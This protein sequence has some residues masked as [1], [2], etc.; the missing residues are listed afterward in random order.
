[1]TISEQAPEPSLRARAA[2]GVLWTVAQKWGV[3]V[4]SLVTLAVL[5]RL[6]EPHEFGVV[7]MAMVYIALLNL[8]ADFGFASYVVQA[9][10]PDQRLLSTAFWFSAGAS[11]LLAALMTA[12]AP[13]VAALVHTPEL[14]PVLQVLALAVV[15]NGCVGT[16]S[17]LLKR[18][19][20]FRTLALRPMVAA[21]VSQAVAVALAFLGAGVWAL[22]AQTLVFSVIGG[23]VIWAGANWR[24]SLMFSTADAR[25]IASYGS[26]VV[27]MD[28]TGNLRGWGETALIGGILGTSALGYWAVATR[29]VAV[30]VDVSAT[31]IVTVATPV[32]ARLKE[33]RERLAAAY[34]RASSLSLAVVG[35]ALLLLAVTAP[36]IIPLVFG[37]QWGPSIVVAQ[38]IPCG[39]VFLFLAMLDR[40]LLLATGRP[41][42][43]LAF[44]V[45]VDACAV[46]LVAAT[47]HAGLAAVAVAE[48]LVAVVSTPFRLRIV[49]RVLDLQLTRAMRMLARLVALAGVSVLPAALLV[50]VGDGL[51]AI[52]TIAAAGILTVVAQVLLLRAAAPEV[53]T[54]IWSMVP[55]RLRRRVARRARSTGKHRA[56]V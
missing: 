29:L 9:T 34:L 54:D 13:L 14:T 42:A 5:A 26:H 38:I 24:P 27:G 51:P 44:T 45:P 39:T 46:A 23:A 7:A 4:S 48:V 10:D 21:L 55:A 20:A 41:A 22:V 53:L 19:L 11:V 30:A 37:S 50:L 49:C 8:L 6:V 35:P 2:S 17:A 28:I 47:A 12:L 3:R 18:R 56:G 36:V 43:A 33:E 1:V 31:T 16:P 40:G 25:Q 52:V 32:F 15:V